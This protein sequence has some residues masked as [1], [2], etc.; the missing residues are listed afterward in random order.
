MC[1]SVSYDGKQGRARPAVSCNDDSSIIES[2]AKRTQAM[3]T[4]ARY[5]VPS[6][7]RIPSVFIAKPSGDRLSNELA[8]AAIR[9]AH[10]IFYYAS[11]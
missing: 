1:L 7:N 6:I 4:R 9:A 5:R 10:K 8:R 11:F 2:S 3:A